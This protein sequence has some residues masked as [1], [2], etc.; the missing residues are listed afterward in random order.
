MESLEEEK[1][2]LSDRLMDT[3]LSGEELNKAGQRLTKVMELIDVKT[4]RWLELSELA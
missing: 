2:K 1:S 3:S 4:N